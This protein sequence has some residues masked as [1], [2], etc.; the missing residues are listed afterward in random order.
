MSDTIQRKR[1]MPQ[2][3]SQLDR[4]PC[5]VYGTGEM[6][7]RIRAFDWSTTPVGPVQQWPELLLSTVNTLLGSRQPMFLCGAKI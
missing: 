3:G 4:P 6:A 2:L 7:D 1:K 5:P